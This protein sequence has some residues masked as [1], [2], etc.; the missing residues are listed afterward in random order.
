MISQ[1]INEY[2]KIG[3]NTFDSQIID[4]CKVEVKRIF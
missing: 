3:Y 4:V 2:S 1:G